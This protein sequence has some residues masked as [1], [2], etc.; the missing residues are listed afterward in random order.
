[1]WRKPLAYGQATATRIFRGDA[2]RLTPANDRES[3]SDGHTGYEPGEDQRHDKQAG[4]WRSHVSHEPAPVTSIRT[5]DRGDREAGIER[6]VRRGCAAD[7]NGLAHSSAV[8][9][10]VHTSGAGVSFPERPSGNVANDGRPLIGRLHD[11]T[12]A[13]SLARA[14]NWAIRLLR[15][16]RGSR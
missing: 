7:A 13:H 2:V 16:T 10:C 11:D 12:R 3:I 8:E 14:S 9:P 4:E 1:M 5:T 6:R 15:F